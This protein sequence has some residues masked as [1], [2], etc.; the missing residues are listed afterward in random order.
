MARQIRRKSKNIGLS[1]GSLVYIGKKRIEKTTI[2]VIDFKDNFFEEKELPA[3]EDCSSYI[4]SDTISWIKVT[5]LDNI[6]MFE[7][8]GEIFDIHP[9]VLEDILN[10]E[11]RPKIEDYDHYLF[12]VF[13]I[14]YYNEEENEI[15]SE[16]VSA[17]FSSKY[18]ITFHEK[19]GTV[20]KP[21]IERIKSGKGKIRKSGADYLAYA[22]IDAAVDSYFNLLELIGE[23][24]ENVE[25][26][27]ILN[28]VPE[29][30]HTIHHLRR[31][32][33][34]LRKSVWPLRE[35]INLMERGDSSYIK[36]STGIYLRDV[37]DHTI[38]IIETIESYRDMVSGMLDTY[39]SSVSNRM[40]EVMKVLTIIATIF[41][42]LTFI[43]GVY[44]MNF[45]HMPE[46]SWSWMYPAGFWI[47]MA[48]IVGVM[49]VYFKKKNWF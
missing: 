35:V 17:V 18:L 4:S 28:P 48:C 47:I 30:L 12:L 24:I 7:K 46:L 19:P 42:P 49:V 31:E 16:Q 9:L 15:Q 14:F 45:H 38:Q 34:I 8:L 5:G 11:Q 25:D 22:L 40:N 32:M 13:K 21:I 23:K 29:N 3:V 6:E 10:T 1:P 2:E 20:F 37:Y 39:L 41:I 44:G 36:K 26:E 33:I 27:L 43:A